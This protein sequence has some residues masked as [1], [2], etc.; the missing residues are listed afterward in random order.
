MQLRYL[1][2]MHVAGKRTGV[3]AVVTVA[4]LEPIQ[5]DTGAHGDSSKQLIETSRDAFRVVHTE[6]TDRI[7][8]RIAELE[9]LLDEGLTIGLVR[10]FEEAV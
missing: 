10:L 6:A 8:E 7:D 9:E 5:E 2:A 3:L 1:A 4:E